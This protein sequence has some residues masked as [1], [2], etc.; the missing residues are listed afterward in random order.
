MPAPKPT[1]VAIHGAFAES[2]SW[3]DVADRL[4][5]EGFPFVAVANPLRSA[6]VDAAAVRSVLDGVGGPVVLVGHSMGGF[7]ATNGA[8]DHAAVRALVY[9]A[10]FAPDRGE[11]PAEL[12][13]RFPGSTLAE[14]LQPFPV[15]EG[16]TDLYIA[17]DRYHHQFAADLPEAQTRRMAATQRPVTEL[18][19]NDHAGEPAWKRI[20]SWFI[21]GDADRNI[22]VEAHRFMAER[23][24]ARRTVEVEGA[25]HV[26]GMSHPDALTALIIEAASA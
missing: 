13:G 15:G 10:A 4:L 18:D 5:D 9:V 8:R 7:A 24:G 11:T 12:S 22:P 14:T 2:S 19:L 16:T 25:S 1:V 21:F 26:V 20:P 6:Q 23:A 3:S 17:Q